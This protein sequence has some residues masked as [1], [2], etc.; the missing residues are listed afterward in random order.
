MANKADIKQYIKDIEVLAKN[1][2]IMYSGAGYL[3]VNLENVFKLFKAI[4]YKNFCT[5]KISN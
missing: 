2:Y 4:H 5:N 3:V 1:K